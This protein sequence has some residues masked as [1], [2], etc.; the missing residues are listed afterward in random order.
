[1][2]LHVED[3]GAL[4]DGD[5]GLQVVPCDHP[6]VDAR[7][8]AL[9]DRGRNLGAKGILDAQDAQQGEAGLASV[10]RGPV[11][12]E[13]G[14]VQCVGSE[15]VDVPVRDADGAHGVVRELADGRVHDV[16]RLDLAEVPDVPGLVEARA[17]AQDDLAG[18][19]CVHAV[20]AAGPPHRPRHHLSRGGE[21]L[22]AALVEGGRRS[23][24]HLVPDGLV[25]EAHFLRHLQQG[26][27]R[28]IALECRDAAAG[29]VAD[30]GLIHGAAPAE[31]GQELLEVRLDAAV[32][33][34]RLAH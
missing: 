22:G 17:A 29:L 3:A 33:L 20:A 30:A 18:A 13:R 5:G 28:G 34:Q 31:V 7:L 25:V 12:V 14:G 32:V 24:H 15:H 10:R 27:F 6:D 21:D 2:Q 4:S 16:L 1:M 23:P 11:A 19:L 9:G 8:V 26:T